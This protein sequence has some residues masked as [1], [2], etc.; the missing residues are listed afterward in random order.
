M[1]S[2]SFLGKLLA[3]AVGLVVFGQDVALLSVAVFDVDELKY[4]GRSPLAAC[5]SSPP[6]DSGGDGG[7]GG[8]GGS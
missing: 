4:V 2:A 1:P 5:L 6:S 8:G 7:C 3:V